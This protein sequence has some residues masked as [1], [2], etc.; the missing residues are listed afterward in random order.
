MVVRRKEAKTRGKE[1]ESGE[2]PRKGRSEGRA[3]AQKEPTFTH[4]TPKCCMTDL[5]TEAMPKPQSDLEP[6]ANPPPH[7][8]KGE[9]GR[10]A[11]PWTGSGI[12]RLRNQLPHSRGA[13]NAIARLGARQREDG[14][15]WTT[16]GEKER[17]AGA[18]PAPRTLLLL[19]SN[20][21]Q[22]LH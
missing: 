16:K 18:N 17:E 22:Y 7:E 2:G 3:T 14:A 19:A 9:N 10:K 8:G 1:K 20:R 4:D 12:R 13:K 15:A 5:D 11:S 21:V 6:P